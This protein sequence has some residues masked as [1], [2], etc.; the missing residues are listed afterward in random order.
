M[1]CMLAQVSLRDTI[2]STVEMVAAEANRKG[3][4]IAYHMDEALAQRTLLGDAIRI[5]QVGLLLYSFAQFKTPGRAASASARV[6]PQRQACGD[7]S[8]GQE[9]A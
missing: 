6:R 7:G 9:S 4:D 8:A 2:G 3:L 5:R 1:R